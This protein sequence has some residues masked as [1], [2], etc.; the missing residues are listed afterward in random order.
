MSKMKISLSIFTIDL[1][2]ILLFD[3]EDDRVKGKVID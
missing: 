2:H 3:D 1:R